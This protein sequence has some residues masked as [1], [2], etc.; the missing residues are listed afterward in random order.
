MCFRT[1]SRLLVIGL[2]VFASFQTIAT[3]TF[4]SKDAPQQNGPVAKGYASA[5]IQML[6]DT[7]GV[8]FNFYLRDVH[9]GQETLV[10]KHAAI[11]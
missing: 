1:V 7:Q 2:L 8:N 10:R 5:A 4:Q 11:C 3:A 9:L 6:S